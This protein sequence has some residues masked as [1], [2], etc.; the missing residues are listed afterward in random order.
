MPMFLRYSMWIGDT[1]RRV[2]I[3]RLSGCPAMT[4]GS[5]ATGTA[6]T[7]GMMRSQLRS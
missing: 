6:E 1:L 2:L 7:S 4:A 3:E 5:I